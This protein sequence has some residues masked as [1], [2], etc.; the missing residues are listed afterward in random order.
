MQL[1]RICKIQNSESFL[2]YCWNFRSNQTFCE[3]V[4]KHINWVSPNE[5]GFEFHPVSAND[6][7]KQTVELSI[8]SQNCINEVY[9]VGFGNCMANVDENA[10][11]PCIN[12]TLAG[13]ID[14]G[15]TTHHI[16]ASCNACF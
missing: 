7:K 4:V 2:T 9:G 1:E 10:F 5:S 13:V 12:K 6:M 14:Y 8:L 15:K 11:G 3:G 16:V